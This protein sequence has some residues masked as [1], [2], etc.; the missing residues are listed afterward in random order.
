MRQRLACLNHLTEEAQKQFIK[1]Q[2]EVVSTCAK[3]AYYYYSCLYRIRVC[4]RIC[5]S[6][7]VCIVSYSYS[8]LYRIK[9]IIR[10]CS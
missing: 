10:V 9:I 1:L 8:C 4:I 3:Q 7:R 5:I 6:I 2:F